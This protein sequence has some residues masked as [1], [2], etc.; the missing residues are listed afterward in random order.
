VYYSGSFINGKVFDSNIGRDAMKTG[1]NG[2]LI[3]GFL[4]ALLM[5]DEGSAYEFVIPYQLA[6][7]SEGTT[8]PYTGDV[9]MEPYQTLVF[10]ITFK[11][12]IKKK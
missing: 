12:I 6:Y 2:G 3:A 9:K 4:E 7:G 11:K 10:K 8:N 5:M 1:L